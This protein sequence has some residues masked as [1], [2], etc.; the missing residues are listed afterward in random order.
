MEHIEIRLP[1]EYVAALRQIARS[2]DRTTGQVIRDAIRRAPSGAPRARLRLRA[3]LAGS[4]VPPAGE[5]L[6]PSRSRRWPGA[7]RPRRAAAVQGLGAGIRL[8]CPG[9]EVPRALSRPCPSGHG[10]AGSQPS[11]GTRPGIACRGGAI[12]HSSMRRTA[13]SAVSA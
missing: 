7:A 4:S 5:G 3:R 12:S 1:R 10:C 2:E 9:P 11:G 13:S 8:C 6:H